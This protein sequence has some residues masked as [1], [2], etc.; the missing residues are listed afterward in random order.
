MYTSLFVSYGLI[1][2]LPYN[3]Q[4]V[5]TLLL[6]NPILRK[7]AEGNLLGFLFQIIIFSLLFLTL[8]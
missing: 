3:I 5:L 1:T 7:E 4:Y 8:I 2:V 6:Y